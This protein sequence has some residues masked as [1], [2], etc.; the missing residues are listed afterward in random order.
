M[1]DNTKT[2]ARRTVTG[3]LLAFVAVSVVVLVAQEV[4]RH[5]PAGGGDARAGT[6]PVSVDGRQVV[7]TYFHRTARCVSCW[8]IEATARRVVERDFADA[9]RDGRL[10]WRTVNLDAPGNGHYAKDF[11]LAMA[12]VVLAET[13][14]G[15]TGRWTSLEKVWDHLE[16]EPA[17]ARYIRSETDAFLKGE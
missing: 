3:L 14:N 9:V 17:L 10:A 6:V 13:V 2:I 12:S 1:T 4:R 11:N 8:T 5:A 7:A 15:A 16:D